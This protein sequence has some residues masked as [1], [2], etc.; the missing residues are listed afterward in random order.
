MEEQANNEV[1]GDYSKQI[2]SSTES[3]T[4]ASKLKCDQGDTYVKLD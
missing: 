4:F 1:K 2:D 3:N